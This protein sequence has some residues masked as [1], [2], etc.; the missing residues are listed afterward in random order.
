MNNQNPSRA[1]VSL[2]GMS[3]KLVLS[4]HYVYFEGEVGEFVLGCFY[5]TMGPTQ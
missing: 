4:K 2:S 5:I 3:Q 1:F